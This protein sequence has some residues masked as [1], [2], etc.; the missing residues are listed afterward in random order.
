MRSSLNV[1]S[2][3]RPCLAAM[4]FCMVTCTQDHVLAILLSLPTI[5]SITN[6]VLRLPHP[7]TT[8]ILKL[9]HLHFLRV[10]AHIHSVSTVASKGIELPHVLPRSLVGQVPH[11]CLM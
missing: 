10:L 9:V 3:T 4:E 7:I 11:H 1:A 2:L 5:C 6:Q 8:P